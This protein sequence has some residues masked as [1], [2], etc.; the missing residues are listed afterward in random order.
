MTLAIN[1]RPKQRTFYGLPARGQTFR[2]RPSRNIGQDGAALFTTTDKACLTAGTKLTRGSNVDFSFEAWIKPTSLS[3]VEYLYSDGGYTGTTPGVCLVRT[4]TALNIAFGQ[5]TTIDIVNTANAFPT[6]NVWYHVVASFDRDGNLIVY[7]N[8]AARTTADISAR[9]TQNLSGALFPTLAALGTPT[10]QYHANAAIAHFRYY[11]GHALTAADVTSLY[12]NHEPLPYASLPADLKAKLGTNG[13]DWPLNDAPGSATYLDAHGANHLTFTAAELVTNGTFNTDATGWTA[14][15]G[16]G[17]GSVTQDA[18]TLKLTQGPSSSVWLHAYQGLTTVPGNSYNYSLQLTAKDTA[19]TTHN[20]WAFGT[21]VPVSAEYVGANA[22]DDDNDVGTF[23]GTFAATSATTYCVLTN[24]GGLNK[25][26]KWDNVS[27]KA[28]KLAS[29]AGPSSAKASDIS[30]NGNHATL[31][32]F[33]ADQAQSAWTPRAGGLALTLDGTNNYLTTPQIDLGAQHTIA[34]RAKSAMTN[35]LVL[36]GTSVQ[37]CYAGYA[38][39]TGLYYMANGGYGGKITCTVDGANWHHYAFVR[40]GSN[41]KLYIDGTYVAERDTTSA[42]APFYISAIG[43]YSNNGAY[44]I[45][46]QIDDIR[47]YTVALTP[48]QIA[49]LY[50]AAEDEHPT[51]A[52]APAA[53]WTFNDGPPSQIAANNTPIASIRSLERP[54]V[55]YY[56]TAIAKRPYWRASEMLGRPVARFD[57]IDDY[58]QTAA[59][60]A[61]EAG[62]VIFIGKLTATPNATQI[63]FSQSDT[64]TTERYLAFAA[65]YNTATPHA[66]YDQRNDTS[67]DFL[68]G[69]TDITI[70]PFCII[71]DT[72][73]SAI[74]IFVNGAEQTVTPVLGANNGDWFADVSTPTLT[75]IG[76]LVR[77]AGPTGHAALDL[78]DLAAFNRKLTDQEIAA[79]LRYAKLFGVTAA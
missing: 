35:G 56:Q 74:R 75:T 67:S 40:A 63:A 11:D 15:L 41:V 22:D 29:T 3:G 13:A 65:R 79:A 59:H 14:V 68:R 20:Q 28:A 32:G 10:A 38:D 46:G 54:G 39:G 50:A 45:S 19:A 71:W 66:A 12:N 6:A 24:G 9:A 73:T 61:G 1:R 48:A 44:K 47:A 58:L 62:T 77:S 70:A 26:N 21:T 5:G 37:N 57:G 18:G 33:S 49:E 2:L 34:F 42:T 52:P 17:G 27:L 78:G 60:M 76:A 51:G 8:N 53:H 31:V 43:A 23:T 4:T 36:A 7:V 55:V 25:Y 16:G 72:G 69:S 30:G 64:S